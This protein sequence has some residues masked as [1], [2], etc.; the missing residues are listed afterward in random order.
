MAALNEQ[1]ELAMTTK[2]ITRCFK[3][4][5]SS[6]TSASRASSRWRSRPPQSVVLVDGKNR[7]LLLQVSGTVAC[8][9]LIW[10]KGR[11]GPTLPETQGAEKL[12]CTE[13]SVKACCLPVSVALLVVVPLWPGINK[14]AGLHGGRAGGG[15]LREVRLATADLR[16]SLLMGSSDCGGV[17]WASRRWCR[18]MYD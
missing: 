17:W 3:P 18:M 15:G 11:K 9:H 16:A 2:E 14:A 13:A 1:D 4:R 12:I 6:T 5:S 8:H 7:T 10:I